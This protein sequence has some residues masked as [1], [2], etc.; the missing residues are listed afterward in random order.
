MATKDEVLQK[1]TDYCTEK[2]YTLNDDFRSQFSEKFATANAT[3]DVNDENVL[4]SIKFNLDTAF[5][6]TS[7]ELKIKD[8]TWRT[9]EADYLKQI[10]ELKKKS[11]DP[12][13]A[14]TGKNFELPDDVKKALELV[15]RISKE[16][17]IEDKQK[18]ISQIVTKN[19]TAEQKSSFNAFL[20]TQTIDCEKDSNELAESYSKTYSDIIKEMIGDNK[21]LGSGGA[22]S[23][24]KYSDIW[25]RQ[26]ERI[27]NS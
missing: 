23:G 4:N 22:P 17:A 15:Q 2:Q 3:A 10:E 25:E 6:A 12:K 26:K 16:R 19:F 20:K 7:K 14:D 9:K 1:V 24:N 11:V 21:V 27:K 5:S 18:E 13:P 8:E